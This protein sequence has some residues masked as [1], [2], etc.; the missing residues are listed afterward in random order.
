MCVGKDIAATALEHWRS[1]RPREELTNLDLEEAL[2]AEAYHEL[3]IVLP[4]PALDLNCA[5]AFH[6]F[7]RKVWQVQRVPVVLLKNW[8]FGV[9]S[10][11]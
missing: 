4:P 3:G 11:Y 10:L 9:F 8:G 6:A 5:A 7:R 1:G 2:S